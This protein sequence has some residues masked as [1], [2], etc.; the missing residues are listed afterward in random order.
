MVD[1][2]SSGTANAETTAMVLLSYNDDLVETVRNR[3]VYQLS[4]E[5]PWYPIIFLASVVIVI[6]FLVV[7]VRWWFAR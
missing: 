4:T 5:Q 2:S 7:I 1:G 6:V 3:E